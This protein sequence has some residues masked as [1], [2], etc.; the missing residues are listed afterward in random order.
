MLRKGAEKR[1]LVPKEKEHSYWHSAKKTLSLIAI[2]ELVGESIGHC[3][4]SALRDRGTG[5][6][7]P[8]PRA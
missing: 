3:R 8:R 7:C 2:W 1:E 6:A 4:D 5:T